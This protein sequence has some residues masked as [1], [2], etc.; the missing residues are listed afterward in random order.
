MCRNSST[1][2]GARHILKLAMP[3]SES[4]FQC[5]LKIIVGFHFQA[6]LELLAIRVRRAL[7]S[8]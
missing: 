5:R 1:P 7:F 3:A 8:T 6:N 2:R 4:S